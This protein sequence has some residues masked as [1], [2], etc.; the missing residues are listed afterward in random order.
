[1]R[2]TCHSDWPDCAW[3]GMR[4]ERRVCVKPIAELLVWHFRS[5]VG[6]TAEDAM[7]NLAAFD[8]FP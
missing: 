5:T 7:L 2:K 4:A 1:M 8:K 6:E 3:K